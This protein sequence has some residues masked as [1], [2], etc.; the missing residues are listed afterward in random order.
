MPKAKPIDVELMKEWFYYD[1]TSP[2][3]LRWKKD[4]YRGRGYGVL[5][6]KAMAVAGI[7]DS[8]SY[9]KVGL[10][11]RT[12]AV[13]RIILALH[14]NGIEHDLDTDHIDGNGLNN[15]VCNLRLVTP[16]QNSRNR[17]KQSNNKTG[18]N[19]VREVVIRGF[20]YLIAQ[21]IGLKG[22]ENKC[23]SI[24]KYGYEEALRL[25]IEWRANKIKELNEQGAGYTERHGAESS[26]VDS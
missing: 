16:S 26:K 1:E 12:Y 8:K 23:F 21:I 25:A 5:V 24:R 22:R 18:H 6:A 4:V 14:N 15:N 13:H 10:F 20:H 3:C 9:Y 17:A 19:G 11:S 2:S 7:I